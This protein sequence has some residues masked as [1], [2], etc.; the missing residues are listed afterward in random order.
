MDL[1]NIK[2]F[3][4]CAKKVIILSFSSFDQKSIGMSEKK[5]AKALLRMKK[6][7]E[8]ITNNGYA[9]E[10]YLFKNIIDLSY[11]QKRLV[12][13]GG[14]IAYSYVAYLLGISTID[15]LE[16]DYN[17][18]MFLGYHHDRRP[19]FFLRAAN[20]YK[21]SLVDYLYHIF[22]LYAPV[23][24]DVDGMNISIGK[25]LDQYDYMSI[26]FM[27]N[28]LL[29]TAEKTIRFRRNE[30]YIE[31]EKA[32]KTIF[33][34]S[35]LSGRILPKKDQII[36]DILKWLI[37]N[38]PQNHNM[39][40]LDFYDGTYEGLLHALAAIHGEGIAEA[41]LH[42][43]NNR[44]MLTKDDIYSYVRPYCCS[45]EEAYKL[46][47][48]ICMGR[49]SDP[50]YQGVIAKIGIPPDDQIKLKRIHYVVSEGSLITEAQLVLF[51]ASQF[52]RK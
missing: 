32:A 41:N 19:C 37:S 1:S 45:E 47:H 40:Y 6:E 50:N 31:F 28:P 12:S 11:T 15:P 25:E 43:M 51:I 38:E 2:F 23:L 9:S 8:I 7:L 17:I 27:A 49:G 29:E 22:G 35:Y 10:Y 20:D 24:I 42:N 52:N 3:D 36:V 34:P 46:M 13:I 26:G 5:K 14:Q 48:R 44:I 16:R 4:D 33:L 21:K 18:E 39:S 30:S